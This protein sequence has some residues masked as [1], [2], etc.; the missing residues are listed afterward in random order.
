[1]LCRRSRVCNSAVS[2]TRLEKLAREVMRLN[3]GRCECIHAYESRSV[4]VSRISVDN[5]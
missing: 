1:M 5:K 2:Q 4:R 3:L